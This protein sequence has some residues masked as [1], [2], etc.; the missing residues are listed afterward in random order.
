MANFDWHAERSDL[1]KLG[2]LEVSSGNDEIDMKAVRVYRL[3]RVRDQMAWFGIDALILSDPVNIRY[4]TGSRNMQAFSM[5]NAPSRYTLLTAR[6]SILFEFTGCGH[7]GR[8]L[9]TIDE[10]RQAKTAS[11]VAAG[12]DIEKREREWAN[13]MAG[14]IT[15]LVGEGATLG[16][17]RLNANVAIALRDYGLKIVDAQ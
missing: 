2:L 1:P 8:G 10:I 13:E 15:E 12:P 14:L 3:G 9:E 5:R 6:R 11:F 4:A 7:L 17:E 16:L